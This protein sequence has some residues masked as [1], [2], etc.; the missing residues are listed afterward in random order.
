MITGQNK[1]VG[2]SV[3]LWLVFGSF[4]FTYL[5]S[6]LFPTVFQTG[7]STFFDQVFL[8][9]SHL[10][11]FLPVRDP[12]I[13]FVDVNNSSVKRLNN[14]YINRS[15]HARA[16]ESLAAMGVSVQLYDYIFAARQSPEEHDRALIRA[17]ENAGNVFFG[18]VFDLSPKPETKMRSSGNVDPMEIQ[19]LDQNKWNPP[20]ENDGLQFMKG[21]DPLITILPLARAAR[22]LGYLNII[23]DHDAI[24]R[25]LPLLIRYENAFYP[26]IA[27]AVLC[28]HL[29]I[30]PDRVR[31]GPGNRIVLYPANASGDETPIRIPIDRHGNMIINFMGPW[32]TFRHYDFADVLEAADDPEEMELWKEELAGK[33]VIISEVRTGSS[34]MGAV[35][36]D[37]NYPLSGLHANAIHTILTQQFIRELSRTETWLLELVLFAL[38]YFIGTRRS[39]VFSFFILIF[40]LAVMVAVAAFVFLSARIMA[41]IS[42][43]VSATVCFILVFSF[44]RYVSYEKEKEMLTKTFSSYFAPTIVKKILASPNLIT[45]GSKKE[46]TILFSDIKNFTTRS[47]TMEPNEIKLLL[48]EYFEEMTKIVFKYHGTLDKYMGDGMMTFFG[49]PDP[50]PDHA[51]RAVKA[52]VEMQ[53]K[54]SLLRKKWDAAGKFPIEIRIGINTGIVAV[55]N[56]G[57]SRR[58]TYTVIGSEVNL[59]QRLETKASVGG[60]LVS[61]R[62]FDLVKEQ[63]RFKPR[64]HV[65]AKGFDQPIAVYE[66]DL[67]GA[68][69]KRPPA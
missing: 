7:I 32:G 42:R 56:M 27:L 59:A 37:A 66:I 21:F 22:G 39:P 49:D 50:Q 38:L 35:P 58:L 25:R 12:V 29:E 41:D 51:L 43:S 23:A 40:I 52:A 2:H 5:F 6:F 20:L 46:L 17:A 63:I 15:Q 65:S 57:S 69:S 10:K 47:S 54:V 48:N 34:D 28:S 4:L 68:G 24:F 18:M 61:Q 13:A 19:F 9:R 26:S 30:S 60:I 33:I 55:G 11:T 62:T 31:V 14:F 67:Q 44:Y 1:P 3:I 53:Q 36:L 45:K 64:H 8:L 16:I